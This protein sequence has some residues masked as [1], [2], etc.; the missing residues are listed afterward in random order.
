MNVRSWIEVTDQSGWHKEFPIRKK[1]VHLGSGP[2]NDVVLQSKQPGAGAPIAR[3]HIQ[4]VATAENASVYRLINLGVES[5]TLDGKSLEPRAAANVSD[6]G[7]L[8]LGEYDLVFRFNVL[9]GE[10]T[11]GPRFAGWDAGV[12]TGA[13]SSDVIGVKLFMPETTL[14]PDHPIEGVLTIRNQGDAPGVQFIL[15][16]EG[17][18]TQD[19][20]IGPGPI[21]FPNAQKQVFVRLYHPR[22]PYPPVGEHVVHVVVTA[23]DDYPGQ[24]AVAPLTVQIV[25]FYQHEL[26]FVDGVAE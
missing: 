14:R 17:L 20:E 2:E 4:L 12:G 10:G 25:P 21:L 16:L 19:Y 5:V 11:G 15:D 6:R 3:R 9:A 7:H 24:R 1:L 23:P 26:R 8:R 18:E 13:I 22:K